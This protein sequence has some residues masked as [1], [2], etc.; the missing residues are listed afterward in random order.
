MSKMFCICGGVCQDNTPVLKQ[1]D[2][3]NNKTTL[4]KANN[5]TKNNKTLKNK[6]YKTKKI[7]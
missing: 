3:T 7:N 2:Q 1:G 6:I 4:I 5:K